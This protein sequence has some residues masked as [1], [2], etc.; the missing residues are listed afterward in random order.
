MYLY[1]LSNSP[2]LISEGPPSIYLDYSCR[3]AASFL[4]LLLLPGYMYIRALLVFLAPGTLRGACVL[5]LPLFHEGDKCLHLLLLGPC[6]PERVS[7]EVSDCPRAC[8]H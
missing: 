3:S 1:N 5:A 4:L 6:F 8:Q 7:G 2:V